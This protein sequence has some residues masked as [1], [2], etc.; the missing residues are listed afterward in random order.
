MCEQLFDYIK[1]HSERE[2][3]YLQQIA[4]RAHVRLLHGRMVS[5]ALQGRLLKMLAELLQP[6]NVLEIGTFVGYS[7]LCLAE[8]APQNAVIHTVEIDD[9]LEDI[10]RENFSSVDFGKKIVLHIDDALQT[11]KNLKNTRFD[12]VFI[13]GD[14]RDY[15][16]YYKAVLPVVRSG[17]VILADNT[18]WN[19]KIF[20]N[21]QHNDYQTKA[22]LEFNDFLAN[23][24]RVEKIILP[25]RDGLTLIKKI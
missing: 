9:E 1:E 10:I 24:S 13:D 21:V 22:I 25:L 20:E 14:K 6:Q 12:L 17:G 15:M 16:K 19:G 7:A 8:G 2:P 4:R 5:G 3:L 23:D 18:L 11:I